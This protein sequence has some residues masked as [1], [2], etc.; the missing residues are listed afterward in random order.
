MEYED[1]QQQVLMGL[2]DDNPKVSSEAV[3]LVDEEKVAQIK[4]TKSLDERQRE[5]KEMLLEREVS[6]S[7]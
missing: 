1:K 5:F 4:A 7:Y 6:M 2:S 3:V